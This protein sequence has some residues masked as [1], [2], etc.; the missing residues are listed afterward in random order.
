MF[1]AS[2]ALTALRIG[3]ALTRPIYGPS[4]FRT[5][6]AADIITQMNCLRG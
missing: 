6:R 2:I 1:Q 5:A 4:A 3:V